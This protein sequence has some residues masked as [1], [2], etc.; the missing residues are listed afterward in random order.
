MT[1]IGA[2]LKRIKQH[3]LSPPCDVIECRLFM[4]SRYQLYIDDLPI[5]AFVGE[6]SKFAVDVSHDL[7]STFSSFRSGL[8]NSEMYQCTLPEADS[9]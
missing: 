2:D 3:E 9:P 7:T 6:H 4:N 5:W 8:G 1:T